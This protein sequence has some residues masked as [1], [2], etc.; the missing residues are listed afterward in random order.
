M[1]NIM[2]LID[3]LIWRILAQNGQNERKKGLRGL[4]KSVAPLV[5]N[6]KIG[7]C[8]FEKLVL[9]KRIEFVPA[10]FLAGAFRFLKSPAHFSKRPFWVKNE[11]SHRRTV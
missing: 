1:P 11:P 8:F 5:A 7:L 2:I 4:I 6:C 3:F 10:G 9:D